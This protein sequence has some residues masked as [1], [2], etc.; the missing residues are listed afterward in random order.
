MEVVNYFSYEINW[1]L[2]GVLSI[3]AALL[4]I[5]LMKIVKTSPITSTNENK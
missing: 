4:C 5:W 2:M 3:I 1:D